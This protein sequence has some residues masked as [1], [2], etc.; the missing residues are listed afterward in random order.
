MRN[1]LA[2]FDTIVATGSRTI[3]A[4]G[5]TQTG[6]VAQQSAVRKWLQPMQTRRTSKNVYKGSLGYFNNDELAWLREFFNSE[7]EIP[8]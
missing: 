5:S 8:V 1:S 6:Y 3:T 4:E 7:G 2:G